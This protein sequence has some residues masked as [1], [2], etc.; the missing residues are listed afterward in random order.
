MYSDK[1]TDIRAFDLVVFDTELT[2]LDLTHEIIEIGYV[3][4]RPH[5]HTISSP[6]Q[7]PDL[8]ST[9]SDDETAGLP[10]LGGNDKVIS[11]S[12]AVPS[13]S[14]SFTQ[15]SRYANEQRE[16]LSAS[17]SR[18]VSGAN[19]SRTRGEDGVPMGS[20]AGTYEKISEGEIKI[21]PTR[22]ATANAESLMISGYNDTDWRGA[23]DLKT[24][25]QQFLKETEGAM[26][27]GHNVAVDLMFLKKSIEE[28]GL[29][30]NYF[31]KAFDTFNIAWAKLGRDL[32]LRKFSL[33]ELAP[34][35]NI[36]Q[37]RAHRALDD[38]R[39]TC[40]VFKKLMAL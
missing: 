20:L 23:V 4:I 5:W 2:G 25:L 39:T 36:D 22:L 35:F 28:C 17:S 40:E 11:K 18:L 26:L 6:R 12:G 37:G 7:H 38:A 27:V 19:E 13:G 16:P 10:R 1:E 24:G 15:S 32:R 3:K 8:V 29:Q 21:K 34:Y 9:R 30:T 14:D 33:S 31:Y